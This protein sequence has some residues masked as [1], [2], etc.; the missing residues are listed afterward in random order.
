MMEKAQ[1]RIIIADDH[2]IFRDGL[3]RLLLSEND[4]AVIAEASD[5][6]EAVSL[7]RQHRPDVLLLDL[8]MPRFPGMAALRELA[9]DQPPVHTILLTAA[10]DALEMTCAWKLGARGIVLKGS[11]PERLLKS[12]RAVC[13][14]ERWMSGD[15]LAQFEPE[16]S[17]GAGLTLRESE[18]VSAIREGYSNKEIA[19]KLSISEET[20][21]RHLSNIYA[22][23]GISSR[24]ELAT[25]SMRHDPGMRG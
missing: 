15:L 21:K 14:G 9:H 11:P 8:A 18:I 24:L 7:A 16:P 22:K 19:S 3:R 23:L 12:I 5:G 2:A 4:F 25:L 20:V 10:I 13:D 17:A 1:I 6:K